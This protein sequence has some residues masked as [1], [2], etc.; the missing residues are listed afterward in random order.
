MHQTV[1]VRCQGEGYCCRQACSGS[2]NDCISYTK[3]HPYTCT[4]RSI[5]YLQGLYF[6]SILPASLHK[7]TVELG[8]VS[9]YANEVPGGSQYLEM[10]IVR[11]N[12]CGCSLRRLILDCNID[13]DGG[14]EAL[15]LGC[16]THLPPLDKLHVHLTSTEIPEDITWLAMQPCSSLSLY[17][18]VI[19]EDVEEQTREVAAIQQLPVARMVLGFSG[20]F[21]KASQRV[22]QQL[23]TPAE[24]HIWFQGEVETVFALPQAQRLC[25]LVDAEKALN[26]SF[27]WAAFADRAG[28]VHLESLQEG[29]VM[30]LD[31]YPG[32]LPCH[33][34]PW[35]L[36]VR[37]QIQLHGFPTSLK[38][39]HAAYLLQNQAVMLAGW[40]E[41]RMQSQLRGT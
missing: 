8:C 35:Q 17:V 32:H 25:I 12:T 20:G 23:S 41:N 9:K 24:L 5:F 19:E 14:G 6:P 26:I 33:F 18:D 2:S 15:A 10:L 7:L 22:W 38:C 34:R 28:C 21:T 16:Q 27:D 11:L 39:K 4:L 3:A 1:L 40:T 31:Q 13:S 29:C 37:G 30:R 36:E